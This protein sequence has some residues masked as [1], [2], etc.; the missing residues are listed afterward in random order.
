MR[1][2]IECVKRVTGLINEQ[3]LVN[4][5]PVT[6]EGILCGFNGDD[7]YLI[8]LENTDTDDYSLY[9]VYQEIMDVIKSM[10][11][12]HAGDSVQVVRLKSFR[13]IE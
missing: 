4:G 8:I 7:T 9:G 2:R 12:I 3:Y 1:K 5:I 11:N 10:G 6:K 13:V